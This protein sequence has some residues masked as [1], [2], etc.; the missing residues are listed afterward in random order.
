MSRHGQTV[1]HAENRYA[2]TSD[3]DLTEVGLA[4]AEALARWATGADLR[5]MYCSP[6]RRAR[7][8]AEPVATALGRPAVVVDELAEVHFGMAE[9]LTIAEVREQD[10]QVAAAFLADPVRHPFPGAEPVEGAAVRGATA[11]RRIAAAHP[12]ERVLVVA[13]NTLLR[14]SLCVLLGI[15]LAHYRRVLPRLDNGT[16]TDIQLTGGDGDLAALRSFNVPLEV[17]VPVRSGAVADRHPSLSVSLDGGT[18][19]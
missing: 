10:P 12:G 1:W 15:P 16:L 5:A 8:T 4:Q 3:V 14:L 17:P 13:H 2:G 19:S 9:G 18:P 11:L 7:L 6:V